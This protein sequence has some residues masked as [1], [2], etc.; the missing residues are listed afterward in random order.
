MRIEVSIK[1]NAQPLFESQY[2]VFET[3]APRAY[4]YH[5]V[6]QVENGGDRRIVAIPVQD[7]EMQAARYASGM[8]GA[9]EISQDEYVDEGLVADLLV[10]RLITCKCQ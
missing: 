9:R 8:Y 7:V 5:G 2:T 10:A 4:D 6:I 3:R 1:V